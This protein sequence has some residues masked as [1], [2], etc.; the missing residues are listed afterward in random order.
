V[1]CKPFYHPR[2]FTSL[3]LI[4]VYIQPRANANVAVKE[5]SKIV[6]NI[7]NT[8][9][10]SH[11]IVLGD[12]N[13]TKMNKELPRYKQHVKCGTR[14]TATL[15]HCYSTI[16]NAYSAIPAPLSGALITT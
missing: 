15:D 11:V 3:V 12:F 7:E 1:Q 2:E 16:S 14:K 8:Y 4:G 5:L 13:H 9:P 6:T 10:D